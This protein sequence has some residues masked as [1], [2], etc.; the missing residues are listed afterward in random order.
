MRPYRNAGGAELW[1]APG[2]SG[3]AQI[4][5]VAN[6]CENEMLVDA[7]DL[8]EVVAKLYEACGL[9]SPVILARSSARFPEGGAP[10]RFGDF[11]FRLGPGGVSPSLPGL[12]A[13]A[14]PPGFLRELAGHLVALAD[15][16]DAEPDPADVDEL[17]VLLMN[18]MNRDV[19]GIGGARPLARKILAAGYSREPRDA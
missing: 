4:T 5:V 3:I 6:G 11:G 12:T 8:P 2:G 10:F 17:A 14:V 15:E 9:P 18:E 19:M 7:C 13:K 16:A 1:I